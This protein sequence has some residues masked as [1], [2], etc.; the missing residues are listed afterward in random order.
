MTMMKRKKGG[1]KDLVSLSAMPD[2]KGKF[3][4][5]PTS[6]G[7]LAK[8]L[9]ENSKEGS[10][11]RVRLG[12]LIGEGEFGEVFTG[13]F[14]SGQGEIINCAVKT[15]K[16]RDDTPKAKFLGEAGIMLQF[17]HPNIVSLLAVV[18]KSQPTMI[19]LEFMPLGALDN[20][21][22][23]DAVFGHL[24]EYEMIRFALDI[25]AGMCGT[26]GWRLGSGLFV[27]AVPF[28]SRGSAYCSFAS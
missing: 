28:A 27:Y 5:P 20:Y 25:A 16:S 4:A 19:V 2:A 3:S 26:L 12:Q 14:M 21:L 1:P 23:N 7:A 15:C 11:Q 18:T 13:E 6:L 10:R 8:F 17:N 22:K 9:G 24:Q